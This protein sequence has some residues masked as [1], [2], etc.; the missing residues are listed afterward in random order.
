MRIEKDYEDLLKSF[1][2]HKV[3]YCIVGAFALAFYAIP[4]YTKDMDIL[5]EPSLENGRRILK[6]LRDFGFAS[7]KLK[8]TDF[9]S[10]GKFV[11]LGY[12]PIRVDLIT[13]IGGAS[14]KEVWK[15]KTKG[16]YGITKTN[17][18]GMNEFIKSK[19][20]AGRK[21]DAADLDILQRRKLR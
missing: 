18:V 5:V 16:I 19:K 13:S 7:L 10:E 11:Q 20:A 6:A 1:N 17:F 14:F 4:R 2:K 21:Q 15:N 3:R 12:E 9:T 8:E